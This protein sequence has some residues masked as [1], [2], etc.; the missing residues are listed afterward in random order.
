MMQNPIR[1]IVLLYGGRVSLTTALAKT[2]NTVPVRLSQDFGRP[3]II[4]TAHKVGLKAE[5]ETWPP[6]VL[7]TSAMT[8]F[9]ITTAY[10]T[11]ATGGIVLKPYTVLE[12]R[13]PNGDVI[14]NRAKE[15]PE[16]EKVK[17]WDADDPT[18]IDILKRD[19]EFREIVEGPK[20]VAGAR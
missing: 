18:T 4:E 12:I 11:F 9:D 13:R 6:M 10:G 7:G 1:W 20:P 17:Y 14:Y 2:Y 8:L 5:L 16:E 19:R 3:A 15:P